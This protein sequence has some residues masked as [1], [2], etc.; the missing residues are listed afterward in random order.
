M[1]SAA[2]RYQVVDG[3][4]G[5]V[6]GVYRCKVRA[7]RRRDRLDLEYGAVRYRVREW[8]EK[9]SMPGRSVL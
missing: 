7:R 6:V 1:E 5:A 8:S 9:G 2:V 4:S 3:K